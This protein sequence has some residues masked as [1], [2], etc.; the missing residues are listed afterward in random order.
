MAW[1]FNFLAKSSS[2]VRIQQMAR[3]H[4][5]GLLHVPDFKMLELRDFLNND[6]LSQG[7]AFKCFV[8]DRVSY[9]HTRLQ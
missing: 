3:D 7:S 2:F 9:C 6:E 4:V 8:L 5:L 1:K